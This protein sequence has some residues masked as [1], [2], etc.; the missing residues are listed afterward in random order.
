MNIYKTKTMIGAI[1]QM[2]P[3]HSFL[4]DRYFPSGAGDLFPTEEVLVEYKDA[5]GNKLAPIV[6]PRKGDISSHFLHHRHTR[7]R[8]RSCKSSHKRSKMRR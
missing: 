2:E 3:V 8:Y 6:L 5:T 4:R 7:H 1:N